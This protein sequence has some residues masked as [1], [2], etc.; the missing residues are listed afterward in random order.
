MHTA[1][2][3]HLTAS[4]DEVVDALAQA[5]YA[6]EF[7]NFSVVSFSGTIF[8]ISFLLRLPPLYLLYVEKAAR[9]AISRVECDY[10]TT[11]K[12]F[13]GGAGLWNLRLRLRS[14][15]TS[16]QTHGSRWSA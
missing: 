12:H 14:K 4:E 9:D 16:T 3:K 7:N 10:N 1:A 2:L 8:A 5:A 11:Q 6:R 15:A 13:N